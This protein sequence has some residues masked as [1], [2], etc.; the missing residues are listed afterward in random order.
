MT[1]P[2]RSDVDVMVVTGAAAPQAKPG[3]FLHGGVL[4]EVTYLPRERSGF[5][6]GARTHAGGS[7]TGC[8]A[9]IPR[10][11]GTTR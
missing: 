8:G 9:S 7:R 5:V 11:P 1:V 6:A 4:L 10:H 2:A 3:K